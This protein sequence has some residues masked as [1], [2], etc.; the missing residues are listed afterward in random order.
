MSG[1]YPVQWAITLIWLVS[2]C[3][4]AALS[5]LRILLWLTNWIQREII[6]N[7]L[8]QPAS[9]NVPIAIRLRDR[10]R[11]DGRVLLL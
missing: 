4:L 10:W 5:G 8:L 1:T 3:L 7:G 2:Y 6:A 11:I 9:P